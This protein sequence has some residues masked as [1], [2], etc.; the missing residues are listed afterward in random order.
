[1][2]NEKLTEITE[3]VVKAKALQLLSTKERTAAHQIEL[4]Q[5][6]NVIRENQLEYFKH[7]IK[8]KIRHALNRFSVNV[9]DI[10]DVFVGMDSNREIFDRVREAVPPEIPLDYEMERDEFIEII[11]RLIDGR[12]SLYGGLY[13]LKSK[14]VVFDAVYDHCQSVYKALCM[15]ENQWD[16]NATFE[17]LIPDDFF[18]ARIMLK[19]LVKDYEVKLEWFEKTW[20]GLSRIVTVR[21]GEPGEMSRGSV[22]DLPK[23]GKPS[24]REGTKK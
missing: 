19:E 1:M 15:T 14:E 24:W 3:A 9:N 20:E 7:L 5:Y 17:L 2:D 12:R 4:A 23:T 11:A 22:A 21:L 16:G 10:D 13:E 8:P 18:R 6:M